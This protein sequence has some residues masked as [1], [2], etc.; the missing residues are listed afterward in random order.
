MTKEQPTKKELEEQREQ[1]QEEIETLNAVIEAS[2]TPVFDL[3]VGEI[4]K[5]MEYNIAEE[6]WKTLKQNQ[7]KVESYRDVEKIIQSQTDL[8]K[9]KKK[10]LEEVQLK[11]DN[12]QPSLFENQAEPKA[13]GI[14]LKSTELFVGDVYKSNIEHGS[15]VYSYYLV[16]ESS[17]LNESYALIGNTIDGERLLQ[18]PANLDLLLNCYYV[19]NLFIE[20]DDQQAALDALVI[21]SGSNKQSENLTTNEKEDSCINS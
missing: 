14:K 20:D 5:A 6:D 19:G 3:L 16:K 12:Y 10:E 4:K 18:Y 17:E 15:G 1:L 13:T 11:I 2:N 21:I 8:L 7:K 9:R